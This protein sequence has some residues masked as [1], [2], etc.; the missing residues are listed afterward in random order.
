MLAGQSWF[1]WG[2]DNRLVILVAK[3]LGYC[4]NAVDEGSVVS[5][6]VTRPEPV[7]RDQEER[8]VGTVKGER[9]IVREV[10]EARD[11]F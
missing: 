6:K 5:L 3:S 7:Q 10:Y 8:R 11:V 4:T 9:L 1:G 2:L